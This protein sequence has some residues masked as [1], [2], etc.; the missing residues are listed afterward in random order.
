MAAET[1]E[2]LRSLPSTS[3]LLEH[4]EVRSWLD[5]LPRAVVLA[6]LRVAL[7]DAHFGLLVVL[8]VLASA[9]RRLWRIS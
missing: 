1:N 2:L 5:G 9:S 4:D 6:G 8:D 7:D 3:T